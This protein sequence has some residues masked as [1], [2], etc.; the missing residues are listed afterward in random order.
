[1][2]GSLY[3]SQ[4]L[5]FGSPLRTGEEVAAEVEVVS[6]KL[7]PFGRV[8]SSFAPWND[9]GSDGKGGTEGGSGALLQLL[10][11][12]TQT[13]A[14]TLGQGERIGGGGGGG[15]GCAGEGQERKGEEKETERP[16]PTSFV[17]ARFATRAWKGGGGRR[18]GS[19][20]S[21]II[22][23][24]EGEAEALWPVYPKTTR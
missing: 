9:S 4:S 11:Q 10:L 23:V 6:K 22:D 2:P 24:V 5:R 16:L 18:K 19:D 21:M 15:G 14:Q 1:M 12:Q 3:L 8:A 17:R 7:L 20:D 13:Q